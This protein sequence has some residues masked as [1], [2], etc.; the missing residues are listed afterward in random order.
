MTTAEITALV[1][2][3]PTIIGAITALI[4]ALKANRTA[5]VVKANQAKQAG[6]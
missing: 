2:G 3:I 1:T 4:V 6:K 5:N